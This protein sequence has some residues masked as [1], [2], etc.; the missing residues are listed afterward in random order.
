M[1]LSDHWSVILP[2][3]FKVLVVGLYHPWQQTSRIH[4]LY[5]N[6]CCSDHLVSL[7]CIYPPWGSQ[8]QI[9]T[10]NVII[11]QPPWPFDPPWY[12]TSAHVLYMGK[13]M[14]GN[15]GASLFFF[16]WAPS[17]DCSLL[18]CWGGLNGDPTKDMSTLNG[19]MQAYLGKEPWQMQSI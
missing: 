2:S 11:P 18:I 14:P 5:R 17:S 1:P 15:T 6:T 9:L 4:W 16:K 13:T 7:H 3:L 10:I 12:H 8:P 19:W